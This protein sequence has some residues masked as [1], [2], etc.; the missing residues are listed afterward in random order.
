MDYQKIYNSLCI[1]S[2]NRINTGNVT[3][4]HHIVPK[5]MGGTDSISNIAILTPKEHFIAHKLLCEIYPNNSKLSYALWAMMNLNNRYQD[6]KYTISSREYER[7]RNIYIKLQMNP[8]SEEHKKKISKS[9][10][11]DRRKQASI[12]LTEYN[13]TRVHPLKG[14]QHTELTKQKIRKAN[15]GRNHSDETK[16]KLKNYNVGRTLSDETK[17]KMRLAATNR[18]I[19]KCPYCDMISKSVSNM[20]R[21][22]F[23]NCKYSNMEMYNA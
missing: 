21:Y 23:N 18:K 13:K 10:T 4:R 9:W 15:T 12:K 3:E 7:M 11:D 17:Q 8:K 22:H 20:N 2:F 19:I 5:C 6:R 14:K 1:N 16:Q